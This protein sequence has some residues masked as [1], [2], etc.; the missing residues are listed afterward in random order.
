MRWGKERCFVALLNSDRAPVVGRVGRRA[1]AVRI[2]RSESAP[3]SLR[4]VRALSAGDPACGT[5][6]HVATGQPGGTP[7][8]SNRRRDS[9]WLQT[10]GSQSER[11]GVVRRCRALPTLG[12]GSEAGAGQRVVE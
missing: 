12:T 11:A 3:G 1:V 5:R 10:V 9:D 8:R 7:Q 6:V 4:G 2:S